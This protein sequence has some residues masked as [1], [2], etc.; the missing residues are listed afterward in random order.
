M[1]SETMR[2]FIILLVSL[3]STVA[4]AAVQPAEI[5]TDGIILQRDEPIRIWGTADPNE[6]I[7]IQF[8]RQ[9]KTGIADNNGKW[10]ITL[11]PTP[12]SSNPRELTICSPDNNQK[13]KIKNVLVGEVWLAGGQSNMQTTMSYY[14]KTTQSDIDT[15]NDQL[16]RMATIPFKTYIDEHNKKPVWQQATPNTV[17]GFSAT[18]YYFA[19]DLRKALQIPVGIISC[20]VGGTP[21]E[22]W[23]SHKTLSS[24]PLMNRVLE[25]Y[26]KEYRL[27]FSTDEKYL[28]YCDE[29]RKQRKIFDQKEVAGEK[30]NPKPVWEMGPRHF[31][32]PCGLYETMLSQTIP[33]TIRGIIW[34]QGEDN[35]NTRS[36]WHY[37]LVFSAL[38]N[39]WRIDFKNPNLPFLFVQ[40]ATYESSQNLSPAWPELRESQRL[41]EL[42]LPNTGMAVL[43]DGGEQ[44]SIHPH[45]KDKAGHRLALLARNM[46]YGEKDLVCRGPRPVQRK[47]R[48]E[49]IELTFTEIGSGLFLKPEEISAFEVCGL[50]GKFFPAKAEVKNDKVIVSSPEVPSPREVRY[51][52]RKWFVPTLFNKEGL[53]A[54][55]FRTDRQPMESEIR[56]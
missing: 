21:A 48:K 27:K 1:W 46:V 36:G 38:I 49:E 25:N 40:L 42:D 55:P 7:T 4:W 35:A 3:F 6:K 43:V 47:C 5:F 28:K 26:Q 10:L 56:Q 18:A 12:A 29:Y 19:R 20:S 17:P 53:P 2:Q 39:Q 16:L 11:D 45:S 34:Y 15:A 32:R 54:S 8:A 50:N 9:E 23:M 14:K 44:K 51:G 33:Y 24:D 37:R 41:A 13:L 30:P 31:R 52:W 22:A